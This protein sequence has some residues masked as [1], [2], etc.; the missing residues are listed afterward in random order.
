MKKV[1]LAIDI[2]ASSGRHIAGWRQ[3]DQ[4]ITEEVYRFPNGIVEQG[5]HLTWDIDALFKHIKR[6]I[7]AAFEKYR[8]I[9]S[10]AID[11]WGCDYVLLGKENEL[12]PVFAYR[13]GRTGDVIDSV[14][15]IVPFE[16]LY[17]ATGI[18]FQPFN[19]IYQ[20]YADKV[21]GRL[22]GVTDFLMIPEYLSYRLTGLKYHE[23][24]DATTTGLVNAESRDFDMKII[25]ALGLNGLNFE[26]PIM[27]G[28]AVGIIKADIAE[29]V[30]GNTI[31][32]VA[33]SH[34]TAAAVEG[35]PLLPGDA[36]IS[37]GTWSLLGV[38]LPK[39]LTDEAARIGNWSNEGGVGYMRYQ[40]N[41]MGMWLV[42]SLKRELCPD[43]DF[44]ELTEMAKASAF[45]GAV[46]ID[47]PE[48][49]APVS[50]TEA[51]VKAFPK[52]KAPV[53]TGDFVRAALNS[54]AKVYAKTLCELQERENIKITRLV[55]A[56]GG[57]K[58]KLLNDLTEAATGVPVVAMPIEAT[59]IGNLKSQ[60]RATENID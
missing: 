51:F 37:S 21:C 50:M 7:K 44:A 58:N 32:T 8:D 28:S 6:G 42:Q 43:K 29:E 20:L 18:Q 9:Q 14:H 3:G 48:F 25:Y 40:K 55:I 35:M 1:Y 19:T 15:S 46:D 36:Y 56:G 39:A 54:L 22:N 17:A 27:P 57:A 5:G 23:Y 10:V 30:G 52:G 41:I 49:L 38:K 60:I 33:P 45:D 2:G 34:D 26:K 31:V 47:A 59:A 24:T 13:D 4:L 11:T 16:R 53:T 12:R